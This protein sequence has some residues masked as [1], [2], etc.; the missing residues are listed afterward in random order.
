MSKEA[1]ANYLAAFDIEEF[2]KGFKDDFDKRLEVQKAV[3]LMQE[4]GAD[5]G[6]HFSWYLRGPYSPS[7]ADDAYSLLGL[8][9]KHFRKET[10]SV[11]RDTKEKFR[12]LLNIIKKKS[13]TT[14]DESRWLEILSS[15]HYVM[16]HSYPRPKNPE[17]GIDYIL[18]LKGKR[19]PKPTIEES[20][21]ILQKVGLL[22]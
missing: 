2:L 17:D 12:N 4:S 15:V 18:R 9:M 14:K 22:K 16:K 10:Q 19:F 5:L 11:G 13:S 3:Y 6:Y 20:Y 7:L 21:E 8:Q 1:L